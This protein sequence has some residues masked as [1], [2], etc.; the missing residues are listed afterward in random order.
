MNVDKVMMRRLTHV[1]SVLRDD[2]N[3]EK[4]RKGALVSRPNAQ[5]NGSALDVNRR[6]L[7]AT[8]EPT[9]TPVKPAA[10]VIPPNVSDTLDMFNT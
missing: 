8:T 5:T 2:R 7:L 1:T 4:K 10:H 3:R 6:S 9:A